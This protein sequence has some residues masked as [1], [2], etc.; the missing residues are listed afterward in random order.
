[1]KDSQHDV[2]LHHH[3]EGSIRHAEKRRTGT[4]QFADR[5]ARISIDAYRS[6]VPQQQTNNGAQQ[7]ACLATIVAHFPIL[8]PNDTLMSQGSKEEI[9]QTAIVGDDTIHHGGY[10]QVMGL[11]VGTKFLS[12]SILQQE[13]KSCSDNDD[14]SKDAATTTS[15]SSSSSSPSL[16]PSSRLGYG[17][18]IRDCHA[19]VLARRAFRRQLSMEMLTAIRAHTTNETC[20]TV[21]TDPGKEK[22]T[23]D[24][25][26]PILQRI[27]NRRRAA[28]GS[29]MAENVNDEEGGGNMKDDP[30]FELRPGVTLH[31]YTSSAPCGNATIKKFAKMKREVFDSTL[32]PDEWPCGTSHEMIAPHSLRLG[33]FALL[34]KRDAT[35]ANDDTLSDPCPATIMTNKKWPI[36][37]SDEWCPPGTSI[38][39]FQRGSIHSC[40]DKIC[41][42]NCL[43]LQGSLL[44]SILEQP[45]YMS[46]LTVGR[47]MTECICRRAVCCRAKGFGDGRL[48]SKPKKTSGEASEKQSEQVNNEQMEEPKKASMYRL[49]HPSLMGTSVYMNE[50]G[51]LDM[52]GVTSEGQDARFTSNLCWIW[53]PERRNTHN[54]REFNTTNFATTAEC[55]DG[56]TGYVHHFSNGKKRSFESSARCE[57]PPISECSTI[58]LLRAHEQIIT[59]SGASIRKNDGTAKKHDGE[60]MGRKRQVSLTELR[61]LKREV[62]TKYES[63]KEEFFT[64]RTFRQWKRREVQQQP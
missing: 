60:M 59:S 1:M 53:Y 23:S 55:I 57:L 54:N 26:R 36:R 27:D 11:G 37:D 40:S 56:E 29:K 28:T 43:G 61:A 10:L 62:A 15:S 44:S 52:S 7:H 25:Y 32:G 30:L 35:A 4:C 51:V 31:M 18:R 34:V 13:L 5:V 45:L 39:G 33:Q 22:V 64:H 50:S 9:T 6:S 63:A 46:T 2:V 14:S 21:G 38:P 12:E 24:V 41:R 17:T 47:K 58:G 16:S 20:K 3:K 19:E 8:P 49:N 48:C 42:W